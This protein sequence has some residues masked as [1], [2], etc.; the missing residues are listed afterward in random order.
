MTILD[1]RLTSSVNNFTAPSSDQVK[2]SYYYIVLKITKPTEICSSCQIN[3]LLCLDSIL[4]NTYS[5]GSFFN[6][7]YE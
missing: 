6:C 1:Q 7:L 5:K 3:V 2:I 4:A